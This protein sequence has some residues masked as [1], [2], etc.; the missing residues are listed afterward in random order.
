MLSLTGALIPLQPMTGQEAKIAGCMPSW[1]GIWTV[2][3]STALIAVL[4]FGAVSHLVF[5]VSKR[6]LPSWWNIGFHHQLIVPEM[7]L[8]PEVLASGLLSWD[9]R[10]NHVY[11]HQSVPDC[12]SFIR[13][14]WAVTNGN[15]WCHE[16]LRGCL[17][18]ERT[19]FPER[20]D[21][22]LATLHFDRGRY[23]RIIFPPENPP[24]YSESP[25]GVI[26][27]IARKSH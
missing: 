20:I 11:G 10:V 21:D 9:N 13:E 17:E 22:F 23:F 6:E 4:G 7:S 19:I 27:F 15:K 2:R 24:E 25:Q 5:S 1:K 16:V 18:V 3:N 8:T 14:K 12:T 26:S